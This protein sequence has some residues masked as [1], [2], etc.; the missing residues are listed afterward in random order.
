[1]I[2]ATAANVTKTPH[3]RA[4]LGYRLRVPDISAAPEPDATSACGLNGCDVTVL[5][6]IY[7]GADFLQPQ[8]L[9]LLDQ[10]DVS[11]RL[12]WRDDGSADGSVALM[13][14]FAREMPGRL[15]RV[16]DPVDRLGVAASFHALVAQAPA[17]GC[18]AFCDQDDVWLPHKL[19][20]GRAALLDGPQE[21]PA[22]YCARQLLVDSELRPLGTS[23]PLRVEL[24]FPMALAQNIATGCTIM[25]NAAA[26]DLLRAAPPPPGTLHD[27]WSYL[28][29]S[30]ANGRLIVDDEPV[31]LY[32]QHGRNL[33]GAPHT[34]WRRALAALRR[35]PAV[36]M[37]LFRDHVT[38]LRDH[39]D[40]LS[41][42]ARRATSDI[43]D[44]L[45]AGRFE[46]WRV[47]RR[48]RL[49]RQTPLE[50][51]LFSVWFMIG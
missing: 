49:R 9:S 43:G 26:A 6:A 28:L 27:W 44:A 3:C 8:L 11:W 1:L 46:R 29:V 30:G 45:H 40:L 12:L 21:T 47:L 51:A 18:I 38:A 41:P 25:L 34:Q 50:T 35:G 36:F 23:V 14:A 15:A 39:Q 19:A 7:N 17:G 4:Y 37:R 24:E 22:L 10:V 5:L 2:G 32:R 33:I 13:E 31:V 20:R 16:S 48:Y 42:A